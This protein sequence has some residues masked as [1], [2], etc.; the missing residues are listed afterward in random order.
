MSLH[1]T[2]TNV[3][4]QICLT[5]ILPLLCL[6]VLF[7]FILLDVL[8]FVLFFKHFA[9]V[10]NN[11]FISSYESFTFFLF[12]QKRISLQLWTTSRLLLT[13]YCI[14]SNNSSSGG[15]CP[16]ILLATLHQTPTRAQRST[17]YIVISSQYVPLVPPLYFPFSQP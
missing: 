15:E 2:V 7:T 4:F 3:I 9:G 11:V 5:V 14:S 6:F 13:H 17:E 10:Q 1:S 16:D 12:K 8:K